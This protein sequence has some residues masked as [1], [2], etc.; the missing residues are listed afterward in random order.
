MC[1]LGSQKNGRCWKQE[2]DEI[3]TWSLAKRSKGLLITLSFES[4]LSVLLWPSADKWSLMN[5]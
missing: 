5:S 4:L 2:G 1:L 3:E